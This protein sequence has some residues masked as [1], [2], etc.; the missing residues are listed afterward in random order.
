ML[1]FNPK[2]LASGIKQL[3]RLDQAVARSR[4]VHGQSQYWNRRERLYAKR[5]GPD[6]VFREG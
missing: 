4:K 3:Q 1:D 6:R 5:R 2:K